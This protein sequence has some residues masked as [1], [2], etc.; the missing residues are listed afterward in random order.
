VFSILRWHPRFAELEPMN[1][2]ADIAAVVLEILRMGTIRIRAFAGAGESRKCFLEADHLHN[3][4]CIISD[5]LEGRLR[6][7]WD[8]ER[9]PFMQQV[10]E[11]ERRDLHPLWA[12]LGDLIE[13]HGIPPLTIRGRQ[14]QGVLAE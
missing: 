7:Y 9:P 10:P 14:D 3:L 4:P 8:I 6:Y 12:R 2:P 13:K 1:C 5:Y 11:S